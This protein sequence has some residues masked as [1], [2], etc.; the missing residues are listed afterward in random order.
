MGAL[1]YLSDGQ[2]T[3]GPYAIEQLRSMWSLGQITA[4]CFYWNEGKNEWRSIV[5]LGLG[6]NLSATGPLAPLSGT[7]SALARPSYKERNPIGY[8]VSWIGGIGFFIGFLNG[9]SKSG[10]SAGT[11]GS[12]AFAI[13][14]AIPMFLLFAAV[15]GIVGLVAKRRGKSK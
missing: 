2:E 13:G 11:A 4:D 12:V 5:E 15:G 14:F 8:W 7:N 1:I 3:R 9:L 10:A 6:G